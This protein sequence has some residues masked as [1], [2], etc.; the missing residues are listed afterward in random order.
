[1]D[2][3]GWYR[4]FAEVEAAESSP[5][6][7]TLANGVAGDPVVLERLGRLPETKRQPNLMFASV[8][9]LGG[10]TSSWDE[11]RA[12]VLDRW[13]D[14]ADLM[15]R[16][17]TQTNEAARCSALLP[18]L[19]TLHSPIA[20]IE[21]GASAGLCLIPDRYSYSYDGAVIGD[22]PVRIDVDCT[23]PVPVP[24]EMPEIC[25]RRGIDLSPLDVRDPDDVAWLRAC[26]WPEHR[27]RR[28]RLARAVEIAAADPPTI[29]RGDLVTEIDALIEAAPTEAT[30]VVFHS[31]VLS[32]LSVEQ[33]RAFA[34]NMRNQPGVVWISNEAP[35]VVAG[36][37]G[38]PTK[39]STSNA[40]VLGLDGTDVLAYTDPHG[41]WLAWASPPSHA[42]LSTR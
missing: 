41:R 10:P 1:M 16:R 15:T 19:G 4:Y 23:G 17:S 30:T 18:V 11:F 13:D 38:P 37:D 36:L 22:S 12:F 8:Q 5:A 26:I 40:F 39:V 21:V 14:L 20:L 28:E 7:C 31:A 29:V 3:A 6:Y 34:D 25:W 2:T 42:R 33:R 35:G 24:T 9:F 27:A 32:Y